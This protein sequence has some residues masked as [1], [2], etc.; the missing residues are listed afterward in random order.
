MLTEQPV[1]VTIGNRHYAPLGAAIL[2][3]V[4]S[5]AMPVTSGGGVS[6]VADV[7]PQGWARLF[8]PSAEALRDRITPLGE[9]LPPDAV[10]ALIDALHASDRGPAVKGLLDAFFLANLPPPHPAEPLVAAITALLADP[11]TQDLAQAA[12]RIGI[13]PRALTAATKRHFGFPPKLLAMRIRFMRALTPMLT[14]DGPP[15]FAV[16]PAGY[17]DRSHLLR[18]ARRFLGLTPRRFLAMDMPYLRAALRARTLVT[19]VPTPSLDGTMAG[20]G[21]TC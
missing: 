11:A 16:I 2:Y 5:R 17:H 18:D 15:D 21:T 13:S 9:L 7:S 8:A 1:T 19:G 10:S 12:G 20:T 3:G 14:A 6:I 4:T